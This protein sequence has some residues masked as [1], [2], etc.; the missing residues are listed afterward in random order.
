[1]HELGWVLLQR[2]HGNNQRVLYPGR[3]CCWRKLSLHTYLC[4]RFYFRDHVSNG[5]HNSI[6]HCTISLS[7]FLFA[8]EWETH[9]LPLKLELPSLEQGFIFLFCSCIRPTTCILAFSDLPRGHSFLGVGVIS[10]IPSV[11]TWVMW[12]DARNPVPD[13]HNQIADEITSDRLSSKAAE[14][15]SKIWMSI[16]SQ[17]FCST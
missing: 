9:G 17:G 5:T 14:A 4:F 13:W 8:W 15:I 10:A 6:T 3:C 16:A 11:V 1:M 2:L 12:S 7:Y